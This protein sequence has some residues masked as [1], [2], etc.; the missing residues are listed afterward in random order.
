MA[1]RVRFIDRIRAI[2]SIGD[3]PH[4]IAISFAIGIFLG[5]SPLIGLHTV[6]ALAA[7]WIFRLNR[8]VILSGVYVTNPWSVIPIYTFCTWVGTLLLGIDD[9]LPTVDWRHMTMSS[10]FG[11][12]RYILLPFVVGSTVVGLFSSVLSYFVI[13]AMAEK[14]HRAK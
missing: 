7:A 5:M 3:T 12:L 1:G 13:R 14:A 6:L 10:V 2:L 11:D 8:L 9:V 4:K